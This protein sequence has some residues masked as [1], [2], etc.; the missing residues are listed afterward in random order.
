MRRG[1]GQQRISE[2]LAWSCWRK[3]RRSGLVRGGEGAI[4]SDYGVDMVGKREL[5]R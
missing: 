5:R 3:M 1:K 2:G 4:V